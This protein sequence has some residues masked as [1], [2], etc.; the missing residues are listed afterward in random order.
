MG[1]TIDATGAVAAA[2]EM[3]PKVENA[4]GIQPSDAA[5]TIKMIQNIL[6][7]VTAF[8]VAVFWATYMERDSDGKS[9]VGIG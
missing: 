9:K 8:G 4:S 3:L 2:S 6:I 1:G 7:G 5:V